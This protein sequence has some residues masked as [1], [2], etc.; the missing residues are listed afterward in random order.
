MTLIDK[1]LSAS[2]WYSLT[3]SGDFAIVEDEASTLQAAQNRILA[4]LDSW[5]YDD[6][7][8]GLL[9]ELRNTPIQSITNTQVRWFIERSLQP[10]LDANRLLSIVSVIII[11]KREDS[12]QVEVKLDLDLAVWVLNINIAT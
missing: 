8:G 2:S 6:E 11:E 12:I 4:E 10:L 3:N 1:Q 7:Y 9:V 5:I